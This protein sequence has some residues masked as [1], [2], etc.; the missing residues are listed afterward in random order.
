MLAFLVGFGMLGSRELLE[1][2]DLAV[3]GREILFYDEG[4]LVDFD[5]AIVEEGFAP[6]NW[7]S[8]FMFLFQRAKK[9]Y[10]V[11]TFRALPWF[12]ICLFLSQLPSEQ[13]RIS[14]ASNRH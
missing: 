10:V 3:E 4:E 14:L 7:E 1:G 6:G 13:T 12:L 9:T 8:Q 11:P 2:G 5:R